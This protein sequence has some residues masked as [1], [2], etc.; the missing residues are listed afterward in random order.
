MGGCIQCGTCCKRYGMKLEATAL[1]I[2]RWR[3]EKR[4]D[5]LAHVKIEFRGEEAIGG[6]LWIDKDGNAAK[7]CPFLALRD[8]KYY[9]EIQ[10]TKPEVCTWYYCERY[11]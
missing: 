9:C 7:E 1:D 11:I 8:D 3:L 4:D 6:R 2:A 10:D 5:I